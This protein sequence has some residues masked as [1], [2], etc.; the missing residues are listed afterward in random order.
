MTRPRPSG[1]PPLAERR[2]PGL[3]ATLPYP[4]ELG[5]CQSCGTTAD[6]SD[7]VALVRYRE[8]DEWDRPT[9]TLV[10]LCPRCGKQLIEPHAR[11]YSTLDNYQPW[12]GA[13]PLCVGC[14]HMKNLGCSHPSAKA[15]GGPGV[16]LTIPKPTPVH[17]NY[18]GGRGEFKNMYHGPVSACRERQGIE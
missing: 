7:Y 15:N 12:P 16:L 1:V 14:V 4:R 17:L 3:S 6:P 18:G 13:V 8:Y 9:Y 2:E 5:V 11:L 10:V